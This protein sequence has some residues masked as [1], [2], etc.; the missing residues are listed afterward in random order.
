MFFFSHEKILDTDY[1]AG[2]FMLV[3]RETIDQVG[4]MDERFFIYQEEV[5]WCKR[6]WEGG[7][8]VT[9]FPG[10]EAIHHHAASSSRDPNR[11][12][13]AQQRSVLMYWGKYHGNIERW[14]LF[15]ILALRFALRLSLGYLLLV[16]RP[17]WRDELKVKIVENKMLLSDLFGIRWAM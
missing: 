11:F 3:R 8:K 13:L 4:L 10:A 16:I 6:I 9:F 14:L 12:K 2:C 7:W 5:D 1:I 17:G 15:C